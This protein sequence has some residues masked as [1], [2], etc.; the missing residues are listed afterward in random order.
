[1]GPAAAHV[2]DIRCAV[3]G[4]PQLRDVAAAPWRELTRACCAARRSASVATNLA[5]ISAAL[6]KP[7]EDLTART[8]LA[9]RAAC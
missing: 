2:I 8:S 5:A 6:R 3:A 7:V 4:T 1:V 9:A